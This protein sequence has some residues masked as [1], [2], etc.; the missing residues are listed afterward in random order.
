VDKYKSLLNV[1]TV[2][3]N[4]SSLCCQRCNSTTKDEVQDIDPVDMNVA[5]AKE[6]NMGTPELQKQQRG[7]YAAASTS[8]SWLLVAIWWHGFKR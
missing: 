4:R 8:K 3:S 2:L 5:H 7:M 1:D 6:S